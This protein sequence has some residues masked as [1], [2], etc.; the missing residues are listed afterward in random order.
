MQRTKQSGCRRSERGWAEIVERYLQRNV[1]A[2][3]FCR[4]ER[5]SSASLWKWQS[6]LKVSGKEVKPSSFVELRS[7][8][9]AP[10]GTAVELRFPNGMV[11][12]VVGC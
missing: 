5:I 7:A 9:E 8:P 10:I 2:E 12:R 11:L 1:S 6:R 4:R 3:E